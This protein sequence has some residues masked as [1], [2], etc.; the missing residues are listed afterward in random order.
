MEN[1]PFVMWLTMYPVTCVIVDY[2]AAKRKKLQ[3]KKPYSD[4][5]EIFAGIVHIIIYVIIAKFL[6]N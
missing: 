3:N 1:M 4:N 2:Y 5:A 6:L